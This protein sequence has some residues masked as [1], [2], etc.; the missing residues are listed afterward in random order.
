MNFSPTHLTSVETDKGKINVMA[1]K[2]DE[3]EY[4]LE[5]GYPNIR[6]KVIVQSTCVGVDVPS[7]IYIIAEEIQKVLAPIL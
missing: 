6:A 2:V 4:L 3:D 1:K 5:I 7:G